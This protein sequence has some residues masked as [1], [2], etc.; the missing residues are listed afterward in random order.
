MKNNSA[1]TLIEILLVVA[2]IAILAGI[3]IFAINPS[4]QLAETRNTRRT[5]DV[6][7]IYNALYQYSIDHRGA[8]P[9]SVDSNWR[10]L[11]TATSGCGIIC[12][13][14]VSSSSQSDDSL[15]D[16][17]EASF[18]LGNYTNTQ[19]NSGVSLSSSLSGFYESSIKES[20]ENT[21]WDKITFTTTFPSYKELP[22]SNQ[23]ETGYLEGDADMTQNLLLFHM[24]E[25][26]GEI[27][28]FSGNENNGICYDGVSYGE[29]GIF[30][31]ALEFEDD[32]YVKISDTG[33][34]FGQNGTVEAWVYPYNNNGDYAGIIHK[35]EDSNFS[36]EVFTL[37]FW[38][39]KIRFAIS[40]SYNH[41][42]SIDSNEDFHYNQWNHIV[43]TWD[44]N[45]IKIYINGK[46]VGSQSHSLTLLNNSSPI[47]IGAQTTQDYNWYFGKFGFDGLI[48]EVA[49]YK[50]TLT[51]SDINYHYKRG[52]N[53]VRYQV[54]TCNDINCMGEVFVGPN[55][56]T[57]TYFSEID[58]TGLTPEEINLNLSNDKYFQY[59]VLM[60]SP[61]LDETPVLTETKID[62]T[63]SGSS[64]SGNS[65]E[66]EDECLNLFPD[67]VSDY[68]V[69]IPK[70][71]T[72]GSTEKTYYAIKK[73]Y[74]RVKVKACTPELEKEINIGL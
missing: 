44:N 18:D 74:G 42:V 11:G 32:A 37:Q 34:N 45:S 5:V 68:L 13:G 7:T 2:A 12:G 71:P 43:G 63:Y 3:V 39:D 50:K 61:S 36:D 1:F 66:L 29:P 16:N 62:Y 25:S 59:K 72:D 41:Y 31:G 38:E 33:F 52:V 35:G 67:L 48:D 73:E 27:I 19:Y 4:K 21:S 70:D 17:S 56:L 14:G 30:K 40:D 26:S 51:L 10:M 49:I 6:S 23:I 9:S 8:Y 57:S 20:E 15:I 60:E 47:L 53:K 28:D 54:R 24:N 22:S 46:L 58:N 64:I 65:V 55:N 69:E